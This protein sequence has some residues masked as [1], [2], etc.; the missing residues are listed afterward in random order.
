MATQA[1]I[2]QLS[3]N[4]KVFQELLSDLPTPL[5]KWKPSADKWCL[6]EIVCHLY[7]EEREDFRVRIASV[8]EDPTKKLPPIDPPAWVAERKYMEQDF[9]EKTTQL[10]TERKHSVD[11][12]MSLQNAKWENAYQHQHFGPMSGTY[13]L[14]NWVAHDLLHIRQIIRLKYEYLKDAGGQSLEYAGIW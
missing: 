7:D 11:W 1:L 8:L 10:L 2:Q 12:L 4:E 6:L 5:R 3:Q 9:E 14:T 13:F